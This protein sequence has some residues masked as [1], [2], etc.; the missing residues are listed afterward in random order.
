MDSSRRPGR[1]PPLG[2]AADGADENFDAPES[3]QT[4]ASAL[5]DTEW[6]TPPRAQPKPVTVPGDH[7]D[8]SHTL[9]WYDESLGQYCFTSE[10]R[11]LRQLDHFLSRTISGFQVLSVAQA[12][13]A[14]PPQAAN[15]MAPVHRHATVPPGVEALHHQHTQLRQHCLQVI[16][17]QL[18][19]DCWAEVTQVK[20][21]VEIL[22]NIRVT[23]PSKLGSAG[24]TGGT[25]LGT[26]YADMTSRLEARLR[27]WT[28]ILQA[29]AVCRAA[30][31]ASQE[32][33][34]VMPSSETLRDGMGAILVAHA[35]VLSSL[36]QHLQEK[37]HTVLQKGQGGAP[38]Q[39]DWLVAVVA[40][41][42]GIRRYEDT[43]ATMKATAPEFRVLPV[44]RPLTRTRPASAS[45][46]PASSPFKEQRFADKGGSPGA[47][48]DM[49]G[50]PG[51]TWDMRSSRSS[52]SRVVSSQR[53]IELIRQYARLRAE[54]VV[55][56][57][58]AGA[59]GG[60][61]LCN[62][63][64]LCRA[65]LG[66]HD[67]LLA[68]MCE[69]RAVRGGGEPETGAAREAMGEAGEGGVNLGTPGAAGLRSDGL[70]EIGGDA[71]EDAHKGSELCEYTYVVFL[72]N[73]RRALERPSSGI[74][75]GGGP[76]G[77]IL[78]CLRTCWVRPLLRNAQ[79]SQATPRHVLVVLPLRGVGE[80][81]RGS[82]EGFVLEADWG[83]YQRRLLLKLPKERLAP[84][85]EPTACP[86]PNLSASLAG[87]GQ[88]VSRAH[89]EP[90]TSVHNS[91]L[92]SLPA[93]A[94]AAAIPVGLSPSGSS[95]RSALL[96]LIASLKDGSSGALGVP[97]VATLGGTLAVQTAAIVVNW[98]EHQLRLFPSGRTMQQLCILHGD[99]LQLA[100]T[101]EELATAIGGAQA[102]PHMLLHLGGG[103]RIMAS[104]GLELT[105]RMGAPPGLRHTL[106]TLQ[107]LTRRLRLFIGHLT[108]WL[109]DEMGDVSSS[110]WGGQGKNVSAW[111]S[112][113][114]PVG[115]SSVVQR[116]GEE[117]L[118]PLATAITLM[119]K[120]TRDT[121]MAAAGTKVLHS[122]LAHLTRLNRKISLRGARQLQLDVDYVYREVCQASFNEL[123]LVNSARFDRDRQRDRGSNEG[124][125]IA[126]VEPAGLCLDQ[127][128]IYEMT[129][130]HFRRARAIC[131]LLLEEGK[132]DPHNWYHLPDAHV[133]L[134][135]WWGTVLVESHRNSQV[136][137]TRGVGT[138]IGTTG[139]LEMQKFTDRWSNRILW[140]PITHE[141]HSLTA[142]RTAPRACMAV[143]GAAVQT[144]AVLGSQAQV[145]P[146]VSATFVIMVAVVHF[147]SLGGVATDD[148]SRGTFT[149]KAR[150]CWM[151][152][153]EV[154]YRVAAAGP[155]TLAEIPRRMRKPIR[156]Q[157][158]AIILQHAV[159]CYRA[160]RVVYAVLVL[161][162]NAHIAAGGSLSW[163]HGRRMLWCILALH[164]PAK[165]ADRHGTRSSPRGQWDPSWEAMVSEQE[166]VLP[167]TVLDELHP[168]GTTVV[169]KD[170]EAW[171]D[172]E[173]D[174]TF[175]GHPEF[176]KDELWDGKMVIEE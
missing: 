119:D 121:L 71:R 62:P 61:E 154:L 38:Q 172:T 151:Q 99:C 113:S 50:S 63:E 131:Q 138:R 147:W 95:A 117:L 45:G 116:L 123:N 153:G 150:E 51:A 41:Q 21:I 33:E 100:D 5:P 87:L 13:A 139:A 103:G 159:A 37:L 24:P 67:T 165:P 133:H 130:Q 22:P 162:L 49:G 83:F 55:G 167:Y 78:S 94:A 69:G 34:M 169:T 54:Q 107:A 93:P 39:K 9:L 47:T 156:G 68:A 149:A 3:L 105:V 8:F 48:W 112:K 141:W 158:S 32:S 53:I 76:G 92:A 128:Q 157:A 170:E 120:R 75:G 10:G 126:H 7:G 152:T 36:M 125:G 31:V 12:A 2:A 44:E 52:M 144:L 160:A 98:M 57:A 84:P 59:P 145:Q 89:G 86:T 163:M 129:R 79:A 15:G 148:A 42:R 25:M 111:H 136:T 66:E 73:V 137:S 90:A 27:R 168:G 88:K 60:S 127:T 115:P 14:L 26:A 108:E 11:E 97:E 135:C 6:S 40:L 134:R 70:W 124:A 43:V 82:L 56:E 29:P 46:V 65:S 142:G 122:L 161:L 174:A 28:A 4:N 104:E 140:T 146:G 20:A 106:A 132:V 17:S 91:L 96:L 173:L 35:E 19:T 166:E 176:T 143:V 171:L 81:P 23:A 64:V 58:T 30:G 18:A 80:R 74:S 102:E 155:A 85:P 164:S 101:A 118:R 109:A 114:E 77:G 175:G 1:L 16:Q 110:M 72:R